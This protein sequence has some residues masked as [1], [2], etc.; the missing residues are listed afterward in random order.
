MSF[1]SLNSSE[2][3]LAVRDYHTGPKFEKRIPQIIGTVKVGARLGDI[4]IGL[5]AALHRLPIALIL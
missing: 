4:E 5:A 3:A 2:S 1:G